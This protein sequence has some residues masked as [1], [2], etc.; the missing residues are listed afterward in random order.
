MVSA[1]IFSTVIMTDQG[2]IR[3]LDSVQVFLEFAKRY[4]SCM[5]RKYLAIAMPNLSLHS[6]CKDL[7]SPTY[8]W[9]THLTLLNITVPR[10]AL[11]QLSMI[12]N[13]AVLSLGPGLF[14]PDIGVDDNLIR[15]WSRSTSDG[16]FCMLRVLALRDQSCVTIRA[17]EYLTL[18]PTLAIFATESVPGIGPRDKIAAGACGWKSKTGKRSK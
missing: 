10:S 18:F 5:G 13:L 1:R 15:T 3:Q 8:Q 16:A 11:I 9:L 7:T 14:A 12:T 2:C 4:P 17:F 6:Y